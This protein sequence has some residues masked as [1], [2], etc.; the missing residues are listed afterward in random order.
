MGEGW[1]GGVGGGGGSKQPQSA[2][3][4]PFRSSEAAALCAAGS[5]LRGLPP[6]RRLG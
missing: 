3:G 5:G 4:E 2:L 6:A 1:Q